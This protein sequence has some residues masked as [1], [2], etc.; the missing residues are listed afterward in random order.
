MP[1][2]KWRGKDIIAVIPDRHCVRCSG[3]WCSPRVLL[4]ESSPLYYT[5]A[6][7]NCTVR[8]STSSRYSTRCV[9]PVAA[10]C[11]YVTRTQANRHPLSCL[12]VSSRA[13]L[14]VPAEA[15]QLNLRCENLL[16]FAFYLN[17]IYL[18]PGMHNA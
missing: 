13:P 7:H 1:A 11:R 15:L 10:W 17:M 18:N 14:A 5:A 8:Y 3:H 16:T 4:C 6:L 12:Y 2:L 9:Q